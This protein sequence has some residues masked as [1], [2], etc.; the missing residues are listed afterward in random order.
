MRYMRQTIL[1]KAMFATALLLMLG[2]TRTAIYGQSSEEHA[3]KAPAKTKVLSTTQS[4]LPIVWRDPGTVETLDFVGGPG[5]REQAP[6]PPFTF[7]EEDRT[8]SN[9]KISRSNCC[10]SMRRPPAANRR[11]WPS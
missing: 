4:G 1:M 9:P 10:R 2:M 6:K 5:G 7:I 8:G 11:N 3:K